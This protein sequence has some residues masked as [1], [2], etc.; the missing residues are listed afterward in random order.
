MNKILKIILILLQISVMIYKLHNMKIIL[1]NTIGKMTIF[2]IKMNF[3]K[4]QIL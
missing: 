1:L 3:Y 2:M 4:L